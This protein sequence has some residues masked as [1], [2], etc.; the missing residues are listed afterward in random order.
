MKP[1][2]QAPN[3]PAQESRKAKVKRIARHL[4]AHHEKSGNGFYAGFGGRFFGARAKDDCLE[5]SP[6][7]EE[8]VAVTEEHILT[9][10]DHNGRPIKG[11][12]A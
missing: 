2:N 7:L 5:V 11:A 1:A 6:D 3:L 9:F 10:R 4:N 12:G 8:W